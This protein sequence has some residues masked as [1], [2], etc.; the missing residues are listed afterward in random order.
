MSITPRPRQ[1]IPYF[2]YRDVQH[3]RFSL[4][5]L[6]LQGRDA[7]RHVERRHAWRSFFPGEA[8]D[9]GTGSARTQH[10]VAKLGTRGLRRWECSSIST[11]STNTTRSPKRQARRSSTG[12]RRSNTAE[13]TRRSIPRG[14]P[15]SSPRGRRR[16]SPA[17]RGLLLL[18]KAAWR[19]AEPRGTTPPS[20][21]GVAI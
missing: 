12:R 21:V 5:R 2:F 11:T 6:W 13:L 1:I 8:G 10:A 16:A 15:G 18:Q 20:R 3:A 4:P 19:A 7:H 14:I 17:W 9:D